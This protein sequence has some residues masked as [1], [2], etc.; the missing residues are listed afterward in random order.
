MYAYVED[1]DRLSYKSATSHESSVSY[2]SSLK[3]ILSESLD[4][5]LLIC[6]LPAPNDI[7]PAALLH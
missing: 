4:N 2:A 3:S 5:R 1:G 6:L 7:S